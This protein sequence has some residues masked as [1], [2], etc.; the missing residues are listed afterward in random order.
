MPAKP[1][2]TGDVALAEALGK[3]LKEAT[4][5]ANDFIAQQTGALADQHKRARER[6]EDYERRIKDLREQL[7]KADRDLREERSKNLDRDVAFRRLELEGKKQEELIKKLGEGLD[8]I[9]IVG[10]GA[11]AAYAN[12]KHAPELGAGSTSEIPA[13][14]RQIAALIDDLSPATLRILYDKARPA[15]LPALADKAF[16]VSAFPLMDGAVIEAMKRD[17][18]EAEAVRRIQDFARSAGFM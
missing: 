7:D 13:T 6:E 10:K 1:A 9:K 15:L 5:G 8:I 11:L 17:L 12:R 3:A 16:L 4:G 2:K 14:E 18:G